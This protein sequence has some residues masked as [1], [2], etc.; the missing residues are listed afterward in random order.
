MWIIIHKDYI[1]LNLIRL[2][3]GD[4]GHKTIRKVTVQEIRDFLVSLKIHC[5][6]CGAMKCPESGAGVRKGFGRCG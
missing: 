5:G 2:E 3:A 6:V 4:R 1:I